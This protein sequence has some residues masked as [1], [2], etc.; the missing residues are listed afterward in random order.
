MIRQKTAGSRW[1][2]RIK[3]HNEKWFEL[4]LFE[5][6]AASAEAERQ[7]RRLVA[8]RQEQV[9]PD[10]SLHRYVEGLPA[11][12]KAKLGQL[13]ILSRQSAC[14]KSLVE[15]LDDYEAALA[16]RGNTVQH[17]AL[18]KA[19]ITAV[20]K[21]CGWRSWSD[22]K[23]SEL[24]AFLHSLRTPTKRRKGIS[25]QTFNFYLTAYKSF[26]RWM[27]KDRRA[28]DSPIAHLD[29]LNVRTDRRHDRRALTVEEVQRLLTTTTSGDVRVGIT[30]YERSMLYR[31]A[32]ET[33]LRAG[34]LRS[35]MRASFDLENCTV[36]VG[37]SYS[38]HRREDHL[39]LRPDTTAELKRFFGTKLPSA[40]A[41]HM[42]AK[43]Y[44]VEVLK[45]DLRVA[46]IDYKDASGRYADVH[47]LRHTMVSWLAA[48]GVHPRIAQS[49]ARHSTITLTMG[50]YSH[51]LVEQEKDALAKLPALSNAPATVK[52][53]RTGT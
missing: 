41:F 24:T 38:K 21:G 45:H 15:H 31:V 8:A 14:N 11:R 4:S 42:P 26:C 2:A 43:S 49:L 37:A 20:I 50:V 12:I 17:V 48:A 1:S 34:E 9:A 35:L 39:P 46:K 3:D 52:S 10:P 25:A 30:G 16:A 5:D 33:G 47:C 27:V 29:G 51:V 19:R 36:V 53:T 23:A 18:V 32:V 7:I 13:G 40:P 6:Q 28:T 44:L 22:I